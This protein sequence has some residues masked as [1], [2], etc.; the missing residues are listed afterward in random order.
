MA[1][2][3]AV[4]VAGSI[5]FIGLLVPHFLRLSF[6]YDHRFILPAS[7]LTGAVLLMLVVVLTESAQIISLPV[8]MVTATVGGPLLLWA[9]FRGQWR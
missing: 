7:A 9:L 6:G 1:V 8:S 2:G 3:S 4:A 5:A